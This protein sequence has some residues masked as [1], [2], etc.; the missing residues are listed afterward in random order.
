MMEI[1][2]TTALDAPG[3]PMVEIYISDTTPQWCVL[4]TDIVT[5]TDS[6][7]CRY[8]DQASGQCQQGAVFAVNPTSD[9]NLTAF[10]ANAA[11]DTP[12]ATTASSIGSATGSST[13]TAS[14]STKTNAAA[15]H[16]IAVGS[17]ALLLLVA[18]VGFM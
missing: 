12:P 2:D 3:L 7:C 15:Q 4:F 1:P 11:Q 14:H 13:S 6:V 10:E 9:Q 16:N 17:A 8:F 18:V 5:S